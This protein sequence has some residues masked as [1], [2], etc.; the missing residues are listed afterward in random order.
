[1]SSPTAATAALLAPRRHLSDRQARTVAGLL[2]ATVDELREVG[3]DGLTVRNVARRAGVAPATAY[4]YF[5]S[6]EHLV[7]E[8]FWRRLEALPETRIDRR[9]TAASRAAATL[10]EMALLVADEPE[11]AAACTAAMLSID[12]DVKVLRDRIGLT[13]RRRLQAALGDDADP[14]VLRSLEFAVSGAM[15]QA[16]MG[17]LDYTDL[18]DQLARTAELVVG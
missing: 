2:D 7:T 6:R 5:A 11:L 10:A 14:A 15:L 18:P 4:N 12:P 1:M 13:W 8:V 17:H 16:G 9:R 3:Y